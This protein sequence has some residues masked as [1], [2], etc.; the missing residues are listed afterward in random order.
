MFNSF[1]VDKKGLSFKDKKLVIPKDMRENL[2]RAIH[3]DHAGRDAMLREA[4]DVWW[5][6]IHRDVVEKVQKCKCLKAGKNLKCIKYQ[7]NPENYQRQRN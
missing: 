4:A 7:T 3:F 1:S 2:L 5:A 6:R